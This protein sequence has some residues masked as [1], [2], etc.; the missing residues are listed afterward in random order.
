MTGNLNCYSNYLAR[1]RAEN[2]IQSL[3]DCTP[4]TAIN[5]PPELPPILSQSCCGKGRIVLGQSRI[6]NKKISEGT[7]FTNTPTNLICTI[8]FCAANPSCNCGICAQPKRL[9]CLS[10]RLVVVDPTPDCVVHLFFSVYHGNNNVYN[11]CHEYT[12]GMSPNY[13]G[14]ATFDVYLDIP[15]NDTTAHQAKIYATST[16]TT[17]FLSANQGAYSAAFP[18]GISFITVEDA[19]GVA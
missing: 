4:D 8:P 2:Y 1:I 10:A 17:C 5:C 3:P 14:T 19:G 16:S 6:R 13:S 9:V 7:T 15:A 12:T 11:L 18:A